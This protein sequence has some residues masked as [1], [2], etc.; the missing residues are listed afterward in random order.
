MKFGMKL[1]SEVVRSTPQRRTR[2]LSYKKLK[3]QIKI[4]EKLLR[5]ES[6]FSFY[7]LL[8]RELDKVNEFFIDKEEDFIIKMK[9]LRIR[10]A[11]INCGEEKLKLQK[12]ILEFHAEMVSLLQYSVL[13]FTG[14]MKI[15]KKH[16]K[17]AGT[18]THLPF[19]IEAMQQP[20][21]SPNSLLELMKECEDMLCHLFCAQAMFG[22]RVR[23]G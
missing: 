19:I 1:R 20:F 23:E 16:K 17:I 2:F 15:V 3:K 6:C 7:L 11:S 8:D 18:S 5:S 12:E 22:K 9:E 13:N 14:L 21:F 4:H 10:V